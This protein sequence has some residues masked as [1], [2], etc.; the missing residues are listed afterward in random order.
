MHLRQPTDALCEDR[1]DV[2]I[3]RVARPKSSGAQEISR[4]VTT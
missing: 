4:N 1:R 2:V 3:L